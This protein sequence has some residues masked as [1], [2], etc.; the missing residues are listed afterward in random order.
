MPVVGLPLRGEDVPMSL[1]GADKTDGDG[2]VDLLYAADKDNDGGKGKRAFTRPDTPI[3]SYVTYDPVLR[4]VKVALIKMTGT[5]EKSEEAVAGPD[6]P[7]KCE[8][9]KKS[10][11]TLAAVATSVIKSE[12]EEESNGTAATAAVKEEKGKEEEKPTFDEKLGLLQLKREK[13]DVLTMGAEAMDNHLYARNKLPLFP[14]SCLERYSSEVDEERLSFYPNSPPSERK[15][16]EHAKYLY[17]WGRAYGSMPFGF[18]ACISLAMPE[19]DDHDFLN[20]KDVNCNHVNNIR[21]L[22]VV[23]P[24][25]IMAME[26]EWIFGDGGP[27]FEDG[28]F[29]YLA[30]FCEY[31]VNAL[32]MFRQQCSGLLCSNHNLLHCVRALHS[33]WLSQRVQ[34]YPVNED[35]SVRGPLKPLALKADIQ[36][37][38]DWKEHYFN[39]HASR[40]KNLDT[41]GVVVSH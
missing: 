28:F 23:V 26:Q 10:L 14:R 30:S 3:E 13:A 35:G 19:H 1:A 15:K 38:K 22:H 33:T 12:K 16:M 4:R 34:K 11:D 7:D 39:V 37:E 18:S 6:G 40:N 31:M 5:Q 9:E 2:K 32:D 20:L 27:N 29:S 36:A 8:E 21:F 24:Q 41:N 17:E 25:V